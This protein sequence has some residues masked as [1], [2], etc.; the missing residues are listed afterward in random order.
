MTLTCRTCGLDFSPDPTC[1]RCKSL[2]HRAMAEL[3]AME[4]GF[5]YSV[6]GTPV[7]YAG[8]TFKAWNPT[9][10]RWEDRD[11]HDDHDPGDEA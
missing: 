5:Q 6:G 9:S 2:Y 4:A 10:Q 3:E 8:S 1:P 7:V 11:T